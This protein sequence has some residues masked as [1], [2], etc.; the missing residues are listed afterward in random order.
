MKKV[1]FVRPLLYPKQILANLPNNN[2]CLYIRLFNCME[3]QIY[4][5]FEHESKTPQDVLVYTDSPIFHKRTV[6]LDLAAEVTCGD[7]INPTTGAAY[8]A[9]DAD[10]CAVALQN[11]IAGEAR[12]LVISD[13]QCVFNPSGLVVEGAAKDAAYA[14]LVK[15][16]NRIADANTTI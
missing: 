15:Q 12:S 9:A 2:N 6:I 11:Q 5:A 14:A 4:M 1:A 13:T 3:I 7:V 8:V 10:N 16:G